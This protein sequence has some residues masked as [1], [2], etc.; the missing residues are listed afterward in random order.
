M[1][2]PVK[3]YV[4]ICVEFCED[5]RMRPTHIQWEDGQTFEID[6]VLDVRSA[7]AARA[8]GQGDRYTIKLGEKTTYL[9]FEH[10][11]DYGHHI[12]GRWFVERK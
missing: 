10:N 5:G 2:Q 8:G 11:P 12:L 4:S 3:K 1:C 9:F 7:A 6:R